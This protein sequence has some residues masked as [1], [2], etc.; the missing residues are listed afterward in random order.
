MRLIHSLTSFGRILGGAGRILIAVASRHAGRRDQRRDSEKMRSIKRLGVVLVAGAAA[1]SICLPAQAAGGDPSTPAAA[2]VPAKA[3]EGYKHVGQKENHWC[4]PAS[5]YIMIAGMKHYKKISTTKSKAGSTLTQSRLA[6]SAY[7]EANGGGGTQRADLRNG[8]N[9]W[10]GKDFFDVFSNPSPAQFKDR[11]GKDIRKGYAVAVAAYER[12]GSYHYNGHPKS[13][14]IDHW[15]VARG[16]TA[17]YG[18][19]HFVDPATTVW[20]SVKPYFSYNTNDFV[21][22]FVKPSKAIVW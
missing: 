7:L 18:R 2:S 15:I 1:F 21:N 8:I 3:L 4:G 16:Y 20:S 9:K 6:G 11:L 17:N 12:A 10:T 14:S 13:K 19:T 22:R 5:A